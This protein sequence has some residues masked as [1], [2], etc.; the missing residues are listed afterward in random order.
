[1]MTKKLDRRVAENDKCRGAKK[2]RG[3][4]PCAVGQMTM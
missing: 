3:N 2:G 4:K 1:M